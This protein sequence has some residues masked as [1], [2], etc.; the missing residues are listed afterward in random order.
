MPI[1][2]APPPFISVQLDPTKGSDKSIEGASSN[3]ANLA[4]KEQMQKKVE[5]VAATKKSKARSREGEVKGQWW[6]CTTTEDELRIFEAEGF[7]QPG[8]WRV[9]LGALSPAIEAREWVL[10]RALV[11]RGFSLPPSDFFSEILEPYKLQPHNISPNS[12]LAIA[13]H[14][15]LCEGHL[16]DISDPA[17]SKTLPTFKDGPASETPAWT[18]CPHISESPTLTRMVRRI[19]KLTESGLSG[20]DLTLS[21]FNKRI[22]PLQHRNRLMYEYSGRDDTMRATKDNLSSDALDKRLRVM[23]KIP[24]DVHSHVCQFD[25]YTDGAGTAIDSLDE[26]DLGTLTRVLHAGM[27]NLEAA[28]NAE[29][30]DS[31]PP[32]KRKRGAA[33]G[34]A[35]KRA[36]ETP[37]VAATKKLEKEKQCLKEI[38]TGKG[39]QATI[40]R[41]F[42][43]PSEVAGSK[44]QKKKLKPSPASMPI[45]QEVEVPPKPSSSDAQDPKNVINLDDIPTPNADSGKDASS[46]KPPLEEPESASAE[47]PAND[48][49]KKLSL[50]GATVWGSA[51]TEQ[52]DLATLEDNLRVFF[53]KHKAVRQNTRQLH[54]DLRTLVLE[55]KAE[56]ERLNKKEA[57]DR[58]AIIFLETRLKNN[59]GMCPPY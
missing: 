46:S 55:Q 48:A 1:S 59:E 7:L 20:K 29:I 5:E 16:R 4:G 8:S 9:V 24:R 39:S 2:S 26:K 51:E 27:S 36:C 40:E 57:E 49:A 53:V 19:Y 18:N 58:H 54:E 17:S 38:D 23:I 10:T 30:P 22:Q 13:N 50:S 37:S 44:P 3:P 35:S 33:S 34:S 41:F 12:V 14:V 47:A 56:I 45:T 15:I 6:P 25:I 31:A 42:N 32:A 52:Q 43:K 21:W 11:E 28:S